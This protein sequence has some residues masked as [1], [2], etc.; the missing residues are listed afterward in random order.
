MD[1]FTQTRLIIFLIV[2][3]V[4]PFWVAGVISKRRRFA[5]FAALARSRSGA[6]STARENSCRGSPST[7]TVGG[8]RCAANT[9]A[10]LALKGAVGLW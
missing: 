2:L 7:W 3:A 10:G 8:W 6:R 5:R 4:A 9:L 1:E